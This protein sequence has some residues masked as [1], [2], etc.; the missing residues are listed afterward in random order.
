MGSSVV[1]DVNVLTLSF[2]L[3]FQFQFRPVHN[4]EEMGT[5]V[6]APFLV[7]SFWNVGD[8]RLLTLTLLEQQTTRRTMVAHQPALEG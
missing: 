2:T 5:M 6:S 7:S 8:G 3:F 4:S 1:V